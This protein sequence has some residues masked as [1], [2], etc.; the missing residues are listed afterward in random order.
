[1]FRQRLYLFVILLI[2]T[3]NAL[4]AEDEVTYIV[5]ENLKL[6]EDQDLSNAMITIMPKG[7]QLEL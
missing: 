4:S 6:R 7:A 5:N 1:M 2:L 3:L